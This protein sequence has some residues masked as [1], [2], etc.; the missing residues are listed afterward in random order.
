MTPVIFAI[1]PGLA[2]MGLAIVDASTRRLVDADIFMSKKAD[3]SRQVFASSDTMHRGASAYKFLK[4]HLK[5]SQERGE[6]VVMVAHESMSLPRNASSSSKIGV[7][8]GVVT[9]FSAE[10]DVSLFEV[11][12]ASLKKGFAYLG[13]TSKDDVCASVM[14]SEGFENLAEIFERRGIAKTYQ[15]HVSDAAAV[16]IAACETPVAR[17]LRAMK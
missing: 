15:N 9:A 14:R 12:P 1:D 2:Y 17:M 8:F 5:A 3:S 13:G 4:A 10:L 6:R 16:G 7:S 11:S